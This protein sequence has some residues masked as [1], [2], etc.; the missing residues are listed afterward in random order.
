MYLILGQW[1][2]SYWRAAA[3]YRQ[4]YHNRQHPDKN[5]SKGLDQRLQETCCFGHNTADVGWSRTTKT[6]TVEK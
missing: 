2:G 3:D 1:G 4:T 5:I 6:A